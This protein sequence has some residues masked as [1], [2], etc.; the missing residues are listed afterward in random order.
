MQTDVLDKAY[1]LSDAIKDLDLYKELI[2]LNNEIEDKL[3]DKLMA[4]NKAKEDYNEA[5][6]YKDYHPSF[7]DYEKRLVLAKTELY[8]CELVKKYFS[9]YNELQSLLDSMFDEIKMSVS[10]KLELSNDKRRCECKKW[11]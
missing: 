5:Y 7:K 4:F 6:K 3:K 8:S 2:V 1:I 9:K 10:N 11:I